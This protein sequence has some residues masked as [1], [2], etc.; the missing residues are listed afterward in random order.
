[1]L[2]HWLVCSLFYGVEQRRKPQPMFCVSEMP[3]LHSGISIWVPFCWIQRMLGVYFW[4]Q[5]GTLVKEWGYHDLASD[6]EA[7]RAVRK[8]RCNGTER[9]QTQSLFYSNPFYSQCFGGMQCHQNI[10]NYR[11]SQTIRRTFVPEKCDLKST[12]VLYT[13]GKYLFP[14]L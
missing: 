6:N 12:C 3:W 5:S 1:M 14:N 9:A 11:I 8:P 4:G 7:Q 13:K 10:G 2:H